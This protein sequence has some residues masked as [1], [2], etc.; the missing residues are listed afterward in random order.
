M[1]HW[2][3]KRLLEKVELRAAIKRDLINQKMPVTTLTEVLQE[4]EA[5]I[6]SIYPRCHTGIDAE[7]EVLMNMYDD[8]RFL[9]IGA[10][11]YDI[12]VWWSKFKIK[13]YENSNLRS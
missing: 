5:M 4:M 12:L 9:A 6:T 10:T 8:K 7:C 3:L 13:S 11:K 2:N 1:K